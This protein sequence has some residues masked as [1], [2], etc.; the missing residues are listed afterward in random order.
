MFKKI[1]QFIVV[2]LSFPLAFLI[3]VCRVAWAI[4][5]ILYEDGKF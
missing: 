4:G 1:F 2:I 3:L 5:D